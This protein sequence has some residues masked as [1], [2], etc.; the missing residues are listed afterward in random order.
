MTVHD[1]A[2]DLAEASLV[3]ED[4]E[5]GVAKKRLGFGFWL[6]VDRLIP[7][8]LPLSMQTSLTILTTTSDRSS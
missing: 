4:P 6:A 1:G 3:D 5:D 7:L 2:V 8:T